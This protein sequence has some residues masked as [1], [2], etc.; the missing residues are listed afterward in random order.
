MENITKKRLKA[1]L[2]DQSIYAAVYLGAEYLLRK[3]IKNE[4]FHTLVTPMVTQY[5]LEYAQMIATGQTIGYKIMGLK[6]E[7]EDTSE[8]TS[9]QILKRMAYRDTFSTID[10]FRDREGF[11]K[12][13]GAVLPHD[14]AAG[15]IVKE[16][17]Q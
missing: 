5:S 17:V 6:L 12:L 2:I 9:N 4:A 8:V 11:E 15:T 7:T 3:K 16:I 10:Y 1:I 13:D 14:K